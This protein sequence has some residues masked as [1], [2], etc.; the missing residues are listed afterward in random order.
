LAV[1]DEMTFVGVTFASSSRSSAQNTNFVVPLV[2][3]TQLIHEFSSMESAGNDNGKASLAAMPAS[4]M[5]EESTGAPTETPTIA[6]A[7]AKPSKS[8]HARFPHTMLRIAPFNTLVREANDVL[9][10]SSGGCSKGVFLTRIDRDSLLRYADPP[11][12]EHSFVFA[13][14][15][16]ELD[17]F[18]M[19]RVSNDFFLGDRIT[20]QSLAPLLH[21]SIAEPIHLKS[22]FEG[23]ES[24]HTISLK[25]KKEYENG[26]PYIPEPYFEEQWTDFEVFGDLTIMQMVKDHITTFGKQS[27]PLVQRWLSPGEPLE[28]KLII[29]DVQKGT[30][31]QR[32]LSEGM[33]IKTLNGHNVSTLKDFRDHFSPADKVW[34]LETLTKVVYKVNF[35]LALKN[36]LLASQS[37]P[38]LRTPAL[39]DAVKTI[40]RNVAARTSAAKQLERLPTNNATA[41]AGNGT[42][43][44]AVHVTKPRS[45]SL[46]PKLKKKANAAV[47]DKH[48][49]A[50][51][52]ALLQ[53]QRHPSFG[54]RLLRVEAPR[55]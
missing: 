33:V 43:D 50:A 22:C 3:V 24:I 30:Y 8:K 28:P 51:E 20:F 54:A 41:A 42:I 47:G 15:D 44:E 21:P 29:T 40:E 32:V 46:D 35:A 23:K 39:L 7:V 49:N 12:Q 6:Q 5:T 1:G 19:G 53:A 18:G 26:V 31:A 34:E 36:Q 10:N 52:E 45:P 2:H 13:I 48:T 25:W 16:I 37:R 14:D 38:Y 4:M 9:Y 55:G 11:V 17:K 27:N